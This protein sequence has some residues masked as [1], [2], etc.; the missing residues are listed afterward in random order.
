MSNRRTEDSRVKEK[1]SVDLLSEAL[2]AVRSG[3]VIVFPTET[4]YGLGADALNEAA[5]MRVASLKGRDPENPIPLIIT[6]MNMLKEIVTELP[7]MAE[8]LI[9]HFWPGP[10]TLVLPARQGL[11]TLLMNRDGGVGVRVSSHPVASALVKG[12]GCPLTATSANSSGKGPAQTIAEARSYFSKQVEIFIDGGRLEGKKGSTVVEIHGD[13]L[14]IIRDGEISP[15]ELREAL[16][17][18]S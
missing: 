10:L 15:K 9:N 6:D 17:S 5:V 8:R 3:E 14:R 2:E 11:P 4:F 13:Q 1:Q 16:A 12:L 7:L 18:V